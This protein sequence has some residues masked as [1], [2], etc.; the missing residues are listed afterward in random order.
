MVWGLVVDTDANPHSPGK[1]LSSL[2]A[3]PNSLEDLAAK[4]QELKQLVTSSHLQ[5]RAERNK[6]ILG[7]FLCLAG[8]LPSYLRK[9]CCPHSG[10]VFLQQLR[11][12]T[13]THRHTHRATGS[14]H[15][16]N[17]NSPP[18]KFWVVSSWQL[19][20]ASAASVNP[21]VQWLCQ[22]KR[23]CILTLSPNC[24]LLHFFPT[25]SSGTFF[26]P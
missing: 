15:F 26:E 2:S 23:H 7:C 5:S 9:W 16:L 6:G 17:W 4:L 19:K 1:S 14:R 11:V 3:L 20:L 18:R 10:W 24:W 22:V 21:C 13:A 25:S 8:F 12:L